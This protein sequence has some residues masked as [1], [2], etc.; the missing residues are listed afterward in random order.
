MKIENKDESNYMISIQ[1]IEQKNSI[2]SIN[3]LN[4]INSLKTLE[5][6]N[7]RSFFISNDKGKSYSSFFKKEFENQKRKK[8]NKSQKLLPSFKKNIIKQVSLK[9]GLKKIHSKIFFKRKKFFQNDFEKK[10]YMILDI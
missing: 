9:F 6:Q 5:N 8:L 3:N 10:K 2:S 1:N 4:S 7:Q